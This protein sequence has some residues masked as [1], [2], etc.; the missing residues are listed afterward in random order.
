LNNVSDWREIGTKPISTDSPAG[1][2]TRYDPDFE[3]MEAQ[4]QKLEGLTRESVDWAQVVNL[5]RKILDERSKDILV[6]SYSALGLLQIE[7]FAGLT[8]GLACLE[9]MISGFWPVLFPELKRLKARINALNWLAA[10]AG[11]AI[12]QGT[13]RTDAEAALACQEQAKLVAALIQEK[14]PVDP[15][16]WTDLLR[17]LQEVA[18]QNPP[19]QSASVPEPEQKP[20]PQMEKPPAAT[21]AAVSMESPEDARRFLND[22]IDPLKRALALLRSADPAAPSPY[23]LVRALTWSE[24]DAL[25]P[26]TESRTLVPPPPAHFRDRCQTLAGNSAWKELLDEVEDR[27]AEFPFW[28]DL[29]RMSDQALGNLGKDYAVARSAARAEVISL[30]ARLPELSELQF[31]DGMPFADASTQRW[32]SSELSP[33]KADAGMAAPVSAADADWL[34]DLR[35]RSRNLV[36]EGNVAEAIGLLQDTIKTSPSER[37]KFL[38]HLEL[39]R[40]CAEAGQL[41]PAL[42]RLEHLDEQIRRFSLESWEPNLCVDVLRLYW[43]TLNQLAQ[44]S[45]QL[46]P[47]MI[48]Q[49]DGVY[50]RLCN[51]DVL[52]GLHLTKAMRR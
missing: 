15:P 31:A 27:I 18:R 26:A 2:P 16:E 42:A 43:E 32:L 50:N 17:A 7:G 3:L 38:S 51:L 4:I 8:K 29:H 37:A 23:S 6:C 41:K 11:S 34:A 30:M 46:S 1:E 45:R 24:I 13:I 21:A 12:A 28:L 48:R 20:Q 36:K 19:A 39:A 47:E 25:P 9:G 35:K 14:I 44:T 10:K 52:A 40:L 22:A 33:A 5:G 49:A